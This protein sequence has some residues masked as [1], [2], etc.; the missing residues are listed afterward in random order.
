MITYQ[1]KYGYTAG[2][3]FL[4]NGVSYVGSYNIHSDG[5]VYTEK[6]RGTTSNILVP[7]SNFSAD[8]I[9][10]QYFKD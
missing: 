4:L 9:T 7:A 1:T 3:E 10:S 6:Y 8:L 5:S 2:N